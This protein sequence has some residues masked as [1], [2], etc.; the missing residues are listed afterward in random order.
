MLGDILERRDGAL[1]ALDRDHALGAE[2]QQGA[3]KPA[4]AGTDLQHGDAGECFRRPRDACGQVEIEQK[5]LAERFLGDEPMPA[6]DF[7]QRRQAVGLFAHGAGMAAGWSALAKRAAS[8]SA[9]TRLVGSATP[10]PAM[11]KAVP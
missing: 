5:I 8:R 4:G 6:N 11:S 1:I 9:A 3:G 10:L 2:R 7:A